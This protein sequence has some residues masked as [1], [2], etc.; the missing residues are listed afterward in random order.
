M[1]IPKSSRGPE[2][3]YLLELKEFSTQNCTYDQDSGERMLMKIKRKSLLGQS[4]RKPGA[5]FQSPL[6]EESQGTLSIH[7]ATNCNMVRDMLATREAHWR[8]RA[9]GVHRGW[10]QS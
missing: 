6:P 2:F 1:R 10:S 4:Q 7:P 5:S 9:Q 3:S 8:L